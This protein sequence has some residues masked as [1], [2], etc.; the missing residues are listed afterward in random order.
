M[1]GDDIA[2]I[3]IGVSATNSVSINPLLTP[4]AYCINE[5]KTFTVSVTINIK[6]PILIYMGNSQGN[7][8]INPNGFSLSVTNPSSVSVALST[9]FWYLNCPPTY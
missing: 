4:T 1:V 9:V 3:W 6:Y 5:P 2:Q 8:G 7:Y